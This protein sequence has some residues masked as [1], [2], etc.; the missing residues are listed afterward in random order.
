ME[1]SP[2]QIALFILGPRVGAAGALAGTYCGVRRWN[3]RGFQR[4][5][6]AVLWTAAGKLRRTTRL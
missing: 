3:V 2:L 6:A 5:L 1:Q 4:S